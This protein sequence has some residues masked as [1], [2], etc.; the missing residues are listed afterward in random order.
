[1]KRRRRFIKFGGG[2]VTNK[3]AWVAMGCEIG[4]VRGLEIIEGRGNEKVGLGWHRRLG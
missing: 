4:F 2:A 3:E 1:M